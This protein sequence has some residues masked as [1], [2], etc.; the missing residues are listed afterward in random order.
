MSAR[1]ALNWPG[2]L[3]FAM[4]TAADHVS[5]QLP[6]VPAADASVSP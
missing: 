2:N 4:H 3:H 1:V 5:E 6:D